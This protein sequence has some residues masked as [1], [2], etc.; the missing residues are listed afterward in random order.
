VA[1]ASKARLDAHRAAHDEAEADAV[2][3]LMTE[4]SQA[5]TIHHGDRDVYMFLDEDDDDTLKVADLGDVGDDED[6]DE[7]D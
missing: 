1:G 3:A 4:S 7:D 5:V 6:L 2:G